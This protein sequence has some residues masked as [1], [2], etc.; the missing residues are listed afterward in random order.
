MNKKEL[1]MEVA[2]ELFAEE[3]YESTGVALIVE[4]AEV[5]KPTL[6]H[7]F[8]NK[9]G[10]LRSIFEK[11]FDPFMKELDKIVFDDNDVMNSIFGLFECYLRQS[12][13]NETFFWLIDHL[14]KAP[15]K[16]MS[17]HIVSQYYSAE[18]KFLLS[19]IERVC[20]NH[21]N[22]AGQEPFLAIN[23]LSLIN[24][25]IEIHIRNQTLQQCNSQQILGLTKQFLYGIYSL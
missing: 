14:R 24:G 6:Y 19:R 12:Q 13:H 17:Y 18:M 2:L 5:T 11:H 22:L 21:P 4:R 10:L 7:Y 16:S 20:L 23:F 3:G 15:V 25:F 9:E 8:G 1:I